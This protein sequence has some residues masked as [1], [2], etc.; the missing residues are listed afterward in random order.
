MIFKGV[1]RVFPLKDNEMYKG[2]SEFWE[3]MERYF[4]LD[5]LIG[6]GLNWTEDSME[7]IIGFTDNSMRKKDT[8]RIK[9]IY[10][11]AE[12]K[13]VLLPKRGWRE[14]KGNTADIQNMYDAIWKDGNLTY[15]LET[16]TDDGKCTLR[17]N[18]TVLIK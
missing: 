2:I 3:T 16:F 4:Y 14:Y 12:Y 7:Y 8:E 17:I 9:K 13:V 11:D 5:K 10:P 18:R 6:L 1:S 15:E